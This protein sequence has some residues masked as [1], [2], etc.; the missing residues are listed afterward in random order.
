MLKTSFLLLAC[1]LCLVLLVSTTAVCG[2]TL[3]PPQQKEGAAHRKAAEQYFESLHVVPPTMNWK[4]VNEAVRD[5]RVYR[6]SKRAEVVQL[7]SANVRGTWREVGSRNQAGRV[8]AVEYDKST[9]RVWVAG[10]GGTVWEGTIDGVSWKCLTDAKRITDPVL[11]KH[12]VLADGAERLIALANNARCFYRDGEDLVWK[13]ATGFADMQ[14]W[15][16]FADAVTI[17]Q[18]SGR[19]DIIAIGREWDYGAA[20]KARSVVYRSID[21]GKSFQRIRWFDGPR[22]ISAIENECFVV[23]GDT[24][25]TV[26]EDGTFTTVTFGKTVWNT[27][28]V[29]SVQLAG[30]YKSYAGMTVSTGGITTFYSSDDGGLLNW[31]KRSEVS[32]MPFDPQSFEIEPLGNTWLYGGVEVLSSTNSG[33]NFSKVNNWGEYYANPETKLHADIPVIQSWVS[34]EENDPTFI[35]TDGGLYVTTDG[36]VTVRNL[37]LDGLNVSQYYSSYTSRDNVDV[38]CAGSQDQGFQRSR[39]DSGGVRWFKQEISGDYSSLTSGDGGHTLFCVYPG[40][41]MYLKDAENDWGVKSLDFQH[42]GHMWLPPLVALP[43]SPQT[44]WLGG[45]TRSGGARVYTYTYVPDPEGLVIDSLD[46][47]F[48]EGLKEVNITALTIAPSNSQIGYVVASQGVVWRTT[49]QGISWQKFA[50]PD[51]LDGHYFSG[52][53]LCVDPNEPYRVYI[54]GS[55]Y[56]GSA[57]YRTDNGGATWKPLEGLPPCLVLSIA[58]SA[59]GRFIAAATDVGAFMYDT[60][61]HVWTDITEQGAP[62][63][64]YW[65]VDYVPQLDIFRFSTYGRGL[66][67]Y[68]ITAITDVHNPHT[69]VH[70]NRWGSIQAE[71]RE[72]VGPVVKV[73]VVMPE[74]ATL[75]WHALDGRKLHTQRI[76]LRQGTNTVRLPDAA[77]GC[78]TVI[79]TTDTGRVLA[80]S[81]PQ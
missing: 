53:A 13:E 1:R 68:A 20:W 33:V 15:G 65:H 18:P 38:L 24:L 43:S 7:D 76:D 29:T 34:G 37:S 56:S 17:T 26:N 22:A 2:Q 28:Y 8:V 75:A 5:A 27:P 39:V 81:L 36:G 71:L 12:V 72:G 14:R 11:L 45:G 67:D 6:M 58:A 73:D 19:L 4:A 63:Q 52:N 74:S 47:D 80:T 10:A 42:E 40:F 44:V 46:M 78:S 77:K 21:T 70:D 66:W 60:L 62:D 57:V 16:W 59:N 54:G 48:G 69:S 55:G 23:H 25:S 51:K 30:S 50:R 32:I 49:N 79:L 41:V 64:T 31:K 3:I 9:Q 61:Q 35:G